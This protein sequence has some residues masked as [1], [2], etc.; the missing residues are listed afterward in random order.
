ML[1]KIR[2]TL[3]R[4][5]S[6]SGRDTALP[7]PTLSEAS[8]S[9]EASNDI[10][11]QKFRP[12]DNFSLDLRKMTFQAQGGGL[13]YLG[14]GLASLVLVRLAFFAVGIVVTISAVPI[15]RAGVSA[16]MKFASQ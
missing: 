11:K 3:F 16:L 14:W 7:M 2:Q 8:P 15:G 13:R 5:R 1:Q 9:A 4:V 12:S 6:E 10:S